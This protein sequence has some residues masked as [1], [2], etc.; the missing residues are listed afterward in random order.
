MKALT[1]SPSSAEA[2]RTWLDR[3]VTRRVPFDRW[4]D[5]V[6][7]QPDDVKVVIEVNAP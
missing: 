2:D 7:R 4:Q 6:Q 3:L 5:A 1:T